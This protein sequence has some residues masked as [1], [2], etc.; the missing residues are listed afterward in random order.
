MKEILTSATG[1][2]ALRT[3]MVEG[4]PKTNVTAFSFP[5]S[6]LDNPSYNGFA[7]NLDDWYGANWV[8]YLTFDMKKASNY[9]D[10]H[11]DAGEYYKFNNK[12]LLAEGMA[13]ISGL[14]CD[15]N[16]LFGSRFLLAYP[17]SIDLGVQEP[18]CATLNICYWDESG[19]LI[20]CVP[21]R[22]GGNEDDSLNSSTYQYHIKCNNFYSIGRKKTGDNSDGQDDPI[23]ID[24]STGYD[25]ANVSISSDWDDT[26]D[27]FN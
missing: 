19:N 13:E 12:Y 26:H 11:L 14:V 1:M 17:Q 4:S 27:L 2:L 7:S 18:K 15:A 8:D 23:D 25:Y 5:A 20:L 21:L 24:E 10:P 9:T 6:L 22:S 16:T 3:R